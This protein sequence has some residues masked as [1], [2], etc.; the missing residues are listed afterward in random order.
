MTDNNSAKKSEAL[1]ASDAEQTLAAPRHGA[2]RDTSA[3]DR[4][5]A[6]APRPGSL[7]HRSQRVGKAIAGIR[8]LRLPEPRQLEIHA[9]FDEIRLTGLEM[10]G[11]PM[12]G[13]TLFEVTGAGKTTTA[14]EYAKRINADDEDGQVSV[15]HIRLDNSGTARSLYVE[16]LA[17]LGDGFALNGTE[18]SLR[19]RTLD[20]LA[21]AGTELV[22]IDESHHGGKRSGFGGEIT[23]SVKLLLD[24]G[25]VPVA[26]LGTEEAVP[27]F[28]RDLELSGRLTAPCSLNG[29]RWHDDYEREVWGGLLANLDMRLVADGILAK[30]IGLDDPD[31]DRP[32]IEA[33]NGVIGQLMG[34]VR[35]AVR[36]AIRDGRDHVTRDDLVTAIDLWNVGHRFIKHNP[37]RHG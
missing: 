29:L 21:D 5:D 33:T 22:I 4:R 12:L 18:H 13:M 30:R 10:K 28:A 16:A 35:T 31:L 6:G 25:V 32:L 20:A 3:R 14:E 2:R 34:T 8:S 37:L 23:S 17:K 11:L 24:G 9:E 15:L 36:T 19:R 26:L 27:I 1:R 7:A